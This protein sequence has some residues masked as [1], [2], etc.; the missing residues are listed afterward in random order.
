MDHLD[1]VRSSVSLDR[2]FFNYF[3]ISDTPIFLTLKSTI[4][5]TALF[6]EKSIFITMYLYCLFIGFNYFNYFSYG[7][8][9]CFIRRSKSQLL[10]LFLLKSRPGGRSD[11]DCIN[12]I[13]QFTNQIKNLDTNINIA[14]WWHSLMTRRLD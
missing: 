9:Q 10:W 1:E 3:C 5:S 6:L 8:I 12:P 4:I 11:N 2:T 14:T 7:F 13:Q